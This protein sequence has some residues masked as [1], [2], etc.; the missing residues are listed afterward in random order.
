MQPKDLMISYDMDEN[1]QG[2]LTSTLN[3]VQTI[4]LKLNQDIPLKLL[5]NDHL[6]TKNQKD[7]EVIRLLKEQQLFQQ[8][9][10]S[11]QMNSQI[12]YFIAGISILILILIGAL[13]Y[14]YFDKKQ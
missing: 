8:S 13:L 10:A 9:R 5:E 1:F 4:D 7:P 12:N 3:S 11:F 6:N 2:D 14:F